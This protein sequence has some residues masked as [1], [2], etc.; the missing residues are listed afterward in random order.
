MLFA[1]SGGSETLGSHAG[2]S[3]SKENTRYVLVRT[4]NDSGVGRERVSQAMSRKS[5]NV[6]LICSVVKLFLMSFFI[7]VVFVKLN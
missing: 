3:I 2:V 7:F 6:F 5:N 4:G 1:F